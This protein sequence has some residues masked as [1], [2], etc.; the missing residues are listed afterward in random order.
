VTVQAVGGLCRQDIGVALDGPQPVAARPVAQVVG[1][2]GRGAEL[3]AGLVAGGVLGGL[4][5]DVRGLGLEGVGGKGDEV[6]IVGDE[7]PA[8]MVTGSPSYFA[9]KVRVQTCIW[10]AFR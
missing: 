7:L 1:R 5:P 8:W 6:V 2:A 9:L 3:G 4:A 10:D